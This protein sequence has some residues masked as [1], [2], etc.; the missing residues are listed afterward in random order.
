[1][2]KTI[3]KTLGKVSLDVSDQMIQSISSDLKLPDKI[4][5]LKLSCGSERPP[6]YKKHYYT[7]CISILRKLVQNPCG[8]KSVC[9]MY[10]RKKMSSVTPPKLMNASPNVIR[11]MLK[12][13][14]ASNYLDR[15]SKG[16]YT[17]KKG[18]DLL[19]L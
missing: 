18:K 6:L 7:R 17:T 12:S 11:I 16:Y 8:V 1:M 14:F 10:K 9:K 4:F 13:L 5:N 19:K 3:K 15:H 2:Q